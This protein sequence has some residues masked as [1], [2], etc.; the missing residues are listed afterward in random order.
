MSGLL[1]P[2]TVQE[3]LERVQELSEFTENC[4]KQLEDIFETLGWSW[5]ETESKLV[6]ATVCEANV[7]LFIFCFHRLS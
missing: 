6:T 1:D 4:K 2:Q 5:D 7:E 3:R